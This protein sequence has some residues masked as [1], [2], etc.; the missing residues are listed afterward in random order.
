[1]FI[2]HINESLGSACQITSSDGVHEALCWGFGSQ[3]WRFEG[4][5]LDFL[6]SVFEF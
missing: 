1:M 5:C 2:L 6:K 3:F 4:Q